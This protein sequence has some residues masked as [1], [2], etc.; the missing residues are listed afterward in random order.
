[1]TNPAMMIRAGARLDPVRLTR[2]M[3]RLEFRTFCMVTRVQVS[4][5][6]AT[7]PAI[8]K[9]I[10]IRETDETKS[11]KLGTGSLFLHLHVIDSHHIPRGSRRIGWG[12]GEG[13]LVLSGGQVM[14][15]PVEFVGED[16]F[17][18][19]VSIE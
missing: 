4:S 10:L 18:G 9:T 11:G 12:K 8:Y 19:I 1:M 7:S 17:I 15:A 3:L 6:P 13:E 5:Y 16:D 2:V 14:G